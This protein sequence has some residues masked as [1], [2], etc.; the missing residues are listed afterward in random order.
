M[1]EDILTRAEALAASERHYRRRALRLPVAVL[2]TILALLIGLGGLYLHQ[3]SETAAA[4]SNSKDAL[5]SAADSNKVTQQ[6]LAQLSTPGLSKA[7]TA[8]ILAELKTA[9]AQ[10]NVIALRGLPGKQGA[11]GAQGAQGI[12]GL[13]GKDSK[14]PGP[15]GPRS[16]VPGPAGSPGARGADSTV[17]GPAGPPGADSTVPG[18]EGSPGAAGADSTVPG[19]AGS[20]GAAGPNNCTWTPSAVDPSQ[21]VCTSPSPAPAPPPVTP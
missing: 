14:V 13:P 19:P 3:Q 12:P 1:P 15:P 9:T 6:L 11:Q 10:T 4:L 16:T 18:P 17:P 20:P 21:L 7:Q 8:Q 2:A 5:R